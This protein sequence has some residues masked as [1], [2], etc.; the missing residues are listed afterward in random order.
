MEKGSQWE[1]T[2]YVKIKSIKKGKLDKIRGGLRSCPGKDGQRKKWISKNPWNQKKRTDKEEIHG[3]I[4]SVKKANKITKQ[5]S[6]NNASNKTEG[7]QKG[8]RKKYDLEEKR[9]EKRGLRECTDKEESHRK[10]KGIKSR[11]QSQQNYKIKN[12]KF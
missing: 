7:F 2:V 3:K 9:R 11:R 5:K 10:V 1:K 6:T 8:R 12:S 4:K